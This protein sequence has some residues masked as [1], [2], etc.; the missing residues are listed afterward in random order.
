MTD[1]TRLD[2]RV[3]NALTTLPVPDHAATGAA[4]QRVLADSDR[5][6]PRA[7]RSWWVPVLAAA[8]VASV[9][10][11]GSL[12]VRSQDGTDAPPT[13]GSSIVGSWERRASG[14]W[15]M[16][17]TS[18][19]IL[20]LDGPAGA[21]SSEGASYSDLGGRIR[22]DAF[23]N[24]ACAELPA[25][26]YTWDTSGRLLTLRVEDDPCPARVDVLDGTWRRSR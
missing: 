5:A 12:A 1:D 23:V 7:T 4:L 14:P 20:T 24:S 15:Q 16:Y 18:S 25:G 13:A 2:A 6:R 17:F 26:V 19:G 9:V 3:R 10:G 11:L 22:V 21:P 8:S